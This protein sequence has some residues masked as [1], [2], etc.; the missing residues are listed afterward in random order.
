MS[1]IIS[2]WGNMA[3][4]REKYLN[5]LRKVTIE[6]KLIDRTYSRKVRSRKYQAESEWF[7]DRI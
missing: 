3:E 7:V 2:A 1:Y 5:E 4:K 6:G